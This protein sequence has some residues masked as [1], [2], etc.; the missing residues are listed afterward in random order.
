MALGVR[1]LGGRGVAARISATFFVATM[2]VFFMPYVGMNEPQLLSEA[3][4]AFGFLG[5]LIARSN[6]RGYVGPVLVLDLAVFVKHNTLA[7]SVPGF[8]CVRSSL[9][10]KAPSCFSVAA[11]PMLP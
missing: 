9:P 1:R 8:L 7:L 6:D 5:F 4:M 10:P 11:A 3:I 2:S